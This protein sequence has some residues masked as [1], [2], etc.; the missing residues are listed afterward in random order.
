MKRLLSL[1]AKQPDLN[2]VPDLT[3]KSW[4]MDHLID[5]L[6][7]NTEFPRVGDAVAHIES[8]GMGVSVRRDTRYRV[9]K[10]GPYPTSFVGKDAHGNQE[11][12]HIHYMRRHPSIRRFWLLYS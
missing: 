11:I 6:H 12:M 3:G 1:F 5:M 8:C 2:A 4:G 7:S 10:M 9:T